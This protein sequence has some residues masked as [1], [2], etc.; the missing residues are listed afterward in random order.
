MLMIIFNFVLFFTGTAYATNCPDIVENQ[1]DWAPQQLKFKNGVCSLTMKSRNPPHKGAYRSFNWND[2]GMFMVFINIDNGSG[3][4]SQQTGARVYYILPPESPKLEGTMQRGISYDVNLGEDIGFHF[5]KTDRDIS[6]VHGCEYEVERMVK[7]E[8]NGGV[9]LKS[10]Q[11]KLV[12]DLGMKRGNTP[13]LERN[14]Q[15]KVTDPLGNSCKIK[16][17][18]IFDYPGVDE[19][20]VKHKTESELHRFLKTK[21]QCANLKLD[22]LKGSSGGQRPSQGGGAGAVN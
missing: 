19:V 6:S 20:V 13:E 14:R 22:F 9:E 12:F 11:N 16:N 3:R 17:S 7:W 15:I 2:N 4:N 1:G 5:L 18:D 21:S 10:C 8:N